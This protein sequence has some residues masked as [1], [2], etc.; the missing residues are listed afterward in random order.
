MGIW[1]HHVEGSL[2]DSVGTCLMAPVQGP[3]SRV[4]ILQPL[5]VL[6]ME[7]MGLSLL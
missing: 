1:D 3:G 4:S 2:G 5:P 7:H 6:I